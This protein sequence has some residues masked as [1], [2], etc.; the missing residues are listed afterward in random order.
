MMSRTAR[1]LGGL[2][3]GLLL[4][5]ASAQAYTI[6]SWNFDEDPG[7]TALDITGN[8]HDAVLMGNAHRSTDTPTG[9]GYSLDLTQGGYAVVGNHAD[10]DLQGHNFHL[11]AWVKMESFNRNWSAILAKRNHDGLTNPGWMLLVGGDDQWG[12][13][14]QQ[15]RLALSINGGVHTHLALGPDMSNYL[16][17]W[18][19]VEAI[20]NAGEGSVNFALNGIM[21]PAAFGHDITAGTDNVLGIGADAYN[22]GSSA[23]YGLDGRIDQVEI[24]VMPEPATLTALVFAGAGLGGYIRRRRK[25]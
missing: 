11:S 14:E 22:G 6:A 25:A 17:Q 8:G 21:T 10:L 19:H 12:R 13:P 18:V 5:T 2:L 23:I 16:G 4:T 9:I 1:T 20:Y 24:A 7:S 15:H 3:L